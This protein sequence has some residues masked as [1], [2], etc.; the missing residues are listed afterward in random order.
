VDSSQVAV[1]PGEKTIPRWRLADYFQP[2][3]AD[4]NHCGECSGAKKGR[5]VAGCG[6]GWREGEAAD[7][8]RFPVLCRVVVLPRCRIV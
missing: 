2:Q 1:E 6:R 4:K 5:F 3:Q 8:T 7:L